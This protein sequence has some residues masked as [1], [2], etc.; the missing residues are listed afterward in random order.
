MKIIA[1]AYRIRAVA[2][3][4]PAETAHAEQ[5]EAA[6]G[7]AA[8][9]AAAAAA[10][11]ASRDGS[12]ASREEV[13]SVAVPPPRKNDGSLDFGRRR[14]GDSAIERF[15][16][17]NRCKNNVLRPLQSTKPFPILI[18]STVIVRVIAP[19]CDRFLNDS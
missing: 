5:E 8:V 9:A 3:E 18:P 19:P 11:A 4:T 13:A 2:F 1:E 6:G 17:R 10:A 15:T 12:E 14:V 7:A 16:L